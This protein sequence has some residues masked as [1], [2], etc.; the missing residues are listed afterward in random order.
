MIP[1]YYKKLKYFVKSNGILYKPTK[2]KITDYVLI[3]ICILFKKTK[4]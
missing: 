2:F 4:T 1:T 3:I